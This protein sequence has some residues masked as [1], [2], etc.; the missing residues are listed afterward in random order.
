MPFTHTHTHTPHIDT[1]NPPA[2]GPLGGPDGRGGRVDAGGRHG[3]RR[4]AGV[5]PRLLRPAGGRRPGLAVRFSPFVERVA[6]A[7]GRGRVGGG[8]G[9]RPQEP[10]DTWLVDVVEGTY[11]EL[12]AERAGGGGSIMEDALQQL[13]QAGWLT[14]SVFFPHTQNRVSFLATDEA[15]AAAA[16]AAAPAAA[17]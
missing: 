10:M 6:A 13:V 1:H 11:A 7:L 8:G 17:K 2:T 5:H 12:H 15:P 14:D 16:A 9:G 3:G 4:A